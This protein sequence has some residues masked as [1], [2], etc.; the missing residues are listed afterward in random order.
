MKSICSVRNVSGIILRLS[1][2]SSK[3]FWAS[4]LDHQSII[5]HDLRTSS[6]E[7]YS[8]HK[9]PK[10]YSISQFLDEGSRESVLTCRIP[11]SIVGI[12]TRGE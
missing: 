11:M 4:G 6:P 5:N 7:L 10:E 9:G 1:L 8:I 3:T 2:L 12:K